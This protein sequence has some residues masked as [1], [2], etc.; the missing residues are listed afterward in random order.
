MWLVDEGGR[1]VEQVL[2]K[3][4]ICRSVN[5]SVHCI[6]G[7]SVHGYVIFRSTCV[8]IHQSHVT[9]FVRLAVLVA[10][11]ERRQLCPLLVPRGFALA[12][13][14]RRGSAATTTIFSMESWLLTAAFLLVRRKQFCS[15]TSHN[16]SIIASIMH[17][18]SDVAC[19]LMKREVRVVS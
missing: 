12:I 8:I 11:N 10:S 19:Q 6:S 7:S 1:N 2:K 13:S 4:T 16:G 9:P 5:V 17:Q 18:K 14:S 15:K 3:Y